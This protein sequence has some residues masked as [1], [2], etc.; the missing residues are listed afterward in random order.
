M[1]AIAVLIGLYSYSILLLGLLGL[2]FPLPI[3]IAS[4]SFACL[5]YPIIKNDF[6]K[7]VNLQK[8]FKFD[9][10]EKLTLITLFLL[11]LVNLVGALGPELSFDALW[12]HLT[13]PKIF[14]ENHSIYFIQGN[15]FYYSLMP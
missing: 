6:Q 9:L 12:Y 5:M 14:I 7:F 1:L 8:N 11:G 10:L 15:L 2:L 4:V 13:I 3:F